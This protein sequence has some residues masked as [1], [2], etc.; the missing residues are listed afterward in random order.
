MIFA[1]D[2]ETIPNTDMIPLL[3][4]PE[5]S[6]V[7][8]DPAKIAAAQATAKADQ[9][10]E[11]ALDPMTGRVCCCAFVGACDDG[12]FETCAM[13]TGATDDEEQAVVAMIMKGLGQPDA[14]IVSWNGVGFD[15]PFIYKRA[16]ILGLDL[17]QFNAPPLTTWTA[18]YK[19]DRHYDFMQIWGGWQS[20]KFAKLDT[21]ARM[22][23]RETKTEDI[24]VTTFIEMMATEEGRAKIA[25][26]C[27]QD[28]RLTWRLFQ[29]MSGFLFA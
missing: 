27:T 5:I 14:R 18:R 12:P 1:L 6:K 16:M 3:P 22:I 8:K 26:Y 28:T 15:L 17:G 20:G 7:L 25:E 29:K 19:T 2:I 4:E 11:M 13:A 24:D 23:L 10:A 9:I 21:V